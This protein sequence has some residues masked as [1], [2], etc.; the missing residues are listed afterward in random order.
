MRM[1]D[2]VPAI[3]TYA[4]EARICVK[5]C[6]ICHFLVCTHDFQILSFVTD[7]NGDLHQER[8]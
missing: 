4:H 5:G 8:P 1:P 3:T 7:L 2:R 6:P